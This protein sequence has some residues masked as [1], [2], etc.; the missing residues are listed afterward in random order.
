MLQTHPT[1]PRTIVRR[2]C[3]GRSNCILCRAG[4]GKRRRTDGGVGEGLAQ[5]K[6]VDGCVEYQRFS[7]VRLS[8]SVALTNDIVLWAKRFTDRLVPV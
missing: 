6:R 2:P 4:R 5:K 7:F 8:K 3:R 1:L